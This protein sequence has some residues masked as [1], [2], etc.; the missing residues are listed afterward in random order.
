MSAAAAAIP[1][2][3][4]QQA[5]RPSGLLDWL[6]WALGEVGF[7]PV[8]ALVGGLLIGI[9][10]TT[11]IKFA[12]RVLKGRPKDSAEHDRRGG[13]Y[14]LSGMVFGVAYIFGFQLIALTGLP[15]LARF[16][17]ASGIAWT[18]LFGPALYDHFW[19]HLV[20]WL[21]RKLWRKDKDGGGDPP[22]GHDST[23]TNFKP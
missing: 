13:I 21:R 8:L 23:Q 11:G 4:M 3:Q 9:A 1:P 5:M 7:W 12:W 2:E 17:V 18:G 14:R 19:N 10:T 22:A 16:L 15:W 20:P 6:W